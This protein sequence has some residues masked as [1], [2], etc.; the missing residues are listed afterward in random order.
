LIFFSHFK[1]NSVYDPKKTACNTLSPNCC[2][3]SWGEQQQEEQSKSFP[4]PREVSTNW[5]ATVR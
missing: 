4:T 2:F 3:W 5:R 1:K